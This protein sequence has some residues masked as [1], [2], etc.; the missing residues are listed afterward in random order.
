MG[1][2]GSSARGGGWLATVPFFA[3][4]PYEVHLVSERHVGWLHELDRDEADG[5]ARCSS[6]SCASTTRCST[7]RCPTSWRSTSGRPTA[8][9]TVRTTSVEFYP[10]N[11][12]ATNLKYL[13]GVGGG[14]G[15]FINDTH[16]EE[17]ATLRDLRRANLRPGSGVS[18]A[19]ALEVETLVDRLRRHEPSAA[20]DAAAIHVVRG[21]GA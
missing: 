21:P 7:G 3:R 9:T 15:A 2:G 5:L 20:G 17:T 18:D 11:R 13:A 16:P 6:P 14:A 8:G 1:G 19:A 12:T 10:P 4:W